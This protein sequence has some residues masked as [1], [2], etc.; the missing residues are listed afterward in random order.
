M[1]ICIMGCGNQGT[2]IA[3]LLAQEDDVEE[4]ILAD[5]DINR[6]TTAEALIKSMGNI[7]KTRSIKTAQADAHN[8]Q[9]IAKVAEGVDLIFNGILS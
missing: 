2:G 9:E 4:L 5:N 1:K 7:V 3:G 8:S 6:A